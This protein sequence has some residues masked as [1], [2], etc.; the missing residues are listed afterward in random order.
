MNLEV[1][2][3]EKDELK[4]WDEIIE[5]SP[6]GSIFHTLKWLNI[7]KK[8]AKYKIYPLI[9]LEGARPI[10]V[11]PI[12]YQKQYLIKT[13]F[14]PPPHFAI[15]YL[16]PVLVGYDQLNQADKEKIYFEFQE[17][18]AQFIYSKIRP[19]YL[20]VSLPE[21]L[22]DSRPF[23]W[24]GYRVTPAYNYLIKLKKGEEEIW[25]DFRKDLRQGINRTIRRGITVHEGSKEELL[26]VHE[27]LVQRYKEQ[28]K[29]LYLSKDYL[30]D[31]YESFYPKNLKIFTAYYENELVGGV[32]ML[33]F[34]NKILS[35]IGSPKSYD[36]RLKGISPNDMAQWEAIKWACRNGFKY[37]EEIGANTKR[38]CYFKSKYNPDLSIYFT[39]QKYSPFFIKWLEIAYK[40][41]LKPLYTKFSINE[42]KLKKN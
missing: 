22:I 31:V 29:T 40:D 13:V 36:R 30:C 27:K 34:K 15:P 2:V 35:W 38:L 41:L 3:A 6:Q 25:H 24:A 16:G 37:Y 10:G 14:S 32:I 28:N 42:S 1:K 4:K 17:R 21:N 26:L 19:N 18:V 8:H 11:F 7:I 20:S 39:A 9:C 12:Y 33:C 23:K 5:A